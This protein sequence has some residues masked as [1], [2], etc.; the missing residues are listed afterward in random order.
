MKKFLLSGLLALMFHLSA[1]S[2]GVQK[3]LV[4]W[5]KDGTNV[6]FALVEKPQITFTETELVITTKES[7][8]YALENMA[9]FT[10]E[11]IPSGIKSLLDDDVAF[12]LDDESLLFPDLKAGSTIILTSLNG[13]CILKKTVKSDGEYAF[14]LVSLCDGVYLVSINGLTYKIVKR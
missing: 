2:D 4:V 10:Y 5:A 12:V 1:L 8:H 14:P 11:P 13:T 3:Q 7:H 9:K 6:A